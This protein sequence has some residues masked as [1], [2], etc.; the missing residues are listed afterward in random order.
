RTPYSNLS[1]YTTLFRSIEDA[2]NHIP[3]FSPDGR[4]LAIGSSTG[5]IMLCDATSGSVRWKQLDRQVHAGIR[6]VAF[7]PDGTI[8]ATGSGRDRKSTPLNSSHWPIP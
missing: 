3:V 8:V 1:P 6:S 5:A 4:M 2:G 7:S